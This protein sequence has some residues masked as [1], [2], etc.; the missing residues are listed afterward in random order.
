MR[1]TLPLGIFILALGFVGLGHL[2]ADNAAITEVFKSRGYDVKIISTQDSGIKDFEFVI[3]AQENFWIPFLASQSKKVLIGVTPDTILSE[4]SGFSKH[5][6]ETIQKV[7][8]HNQ[9]ITDNAVVAIFEKYKINVVHFAGKNAKSEYL[10]L[11]I[12]CPHCQTEITQNFAKRLKSG[13]NVY[14]LVA[15]I[16]GMDS[17]KKAATFYQEIES[18]KSDK[19]KQD[20]INE[21]FSKGIKPKDNI[22]ITRIMNITIELGAAG[23]RGVPYVI[24]R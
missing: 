21:V 8:D 12:N 10:V 2:Y 7:R 19:E 1:K 14:V 17:A 6:T 9:T 16:L 5:L 15:G 4:D 11:D 18:K 3:V 23:L 22:D 13:A 24:E 20:Y